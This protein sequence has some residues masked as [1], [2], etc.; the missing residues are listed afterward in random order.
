VLADGV[1]ELLHNYAA[2]EQHFLDFFPEL[3]G[4]VE[5]AQREA[6]SAEVNAPSLQ[7]LA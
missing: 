1:Q 6:Q 7:R 5:T 3:L 2:L 4:F